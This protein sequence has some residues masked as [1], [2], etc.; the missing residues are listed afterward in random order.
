M[1]LEAL[2]SARDG[3]H[4]SGADLEYDPAFVELNEAAR[5]KEERQVG[6]AM[7]PA[8]EP[9]YADV[10]TKALAILERSHDLRAA[11]RWTEASLRT[12]GLPGLADGIAYIVGCL[13]RHWATC[14]PLVD[15]DDGDP[16]FRVNTIQE[17]NAD[18][19]M[20]GLRRAPLTDS[21]G[22]GRF[23]WRDIQVAEGAITAPEDM[24]TVPD[25]GAITA[26]F[27]DTDPG[28]IATLAQAA[29]AAKASVDEIGTVFM[30]ETPGFGPEL[31]ELSKTLTRIADVLARHVSEGG[32]ASG[33]TEADDQTTE[34]TAAAAPPGAIRT[35]QD[36]ANTL[37]R[38]IAYY[39]RNEPS[40]P[41]PLLLDRAKRL[42]G[43]D[44]L[45]IIKDIAPE[46]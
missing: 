27:E 33:D 46:G 24:E 38:I 9:D 37:D 12:R 11:V 19:A 21:R 16:T 26:A 25:M 5:G 30:E 29:Q 32:G 35:P 28:H 2:L 45:D 39:Q 20:R 23:S 4:P 15:E 13:Q 22:F 40:S 1:D 7:E 44:F 43:A 10:A 17:L 3:E 14:Y 36:V 18:T 31:D 8:E 6:D 42:V 41:V 34:A